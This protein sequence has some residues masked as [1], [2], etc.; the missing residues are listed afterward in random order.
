[1]YKGKCGQ[2]V[3]AGVQGT[4]TMR[5]NVRS[6]VRLPDSEVG[7][8]WYADDQKPFYAE[9][10]QPKKREPMTIPLNAA[11]IF[12]CVLF[13]VF[14]ALALN[15]V[16]R[17]T[18]LAKNIHAMSQSIEETKTKIESLTLQVKEARDSARIGFD[19][20][21]KL[22][23][24]AASEAETIAVQAPG[25]RPFGETS[26]PEGEV[27]PGFVQSVQKTGSR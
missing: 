22:Q 3:T 6:N 14:G 23:M 4:P 21:H 12:L 5:L 18:A 7:G 1:M 25:T 13:V 8:S 10:I 9:T 2:F 24:I 19:A 17:K 15:R 11:L 27:S 20:S 26:V 16:F